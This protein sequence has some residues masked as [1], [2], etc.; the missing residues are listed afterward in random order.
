[1]AYIGVYENLLVINLINSLSSLKYRVSLSNF[2]CFYLGV[3]KS[4]QIV[5]D[6]MS[7]IDIVQ[8]FTNQKFFHN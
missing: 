2:Y 8:K 1:M 3:G 7:I 4:D 5:K 6:Q